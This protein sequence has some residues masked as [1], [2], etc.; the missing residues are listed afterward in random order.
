M[1]KALKIL[2]I[3]L[4]VILFA[5]IVAIVVCYC[6]IPEQ[7]KGVM[8]KIIEYLNT[9]IGITGVSIASIGYIFYKIISMTSI[10]KV[11]LRT[12]KNDFCNTV[13]KVDD[14]LAKLEEKEKELAKKEED[15]KVF[16]EGY[17]NKVNELS[18]SLIKVCET[19]PNAKIKALGEQFKGNVSILNNEINE[20][21]E[22]GKNEFANVKEKVSLIDIQ[23]KYDEL[24]NEL[25]ALK[26]K[27][28]YGEREETT[29]D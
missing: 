12:L 10:G 18:D 20:K 19:I 23:G 6:V 22:Q 29:N 4:Y 15:L 28:E 3:S 13:Q 21:L 1:N 5:C 17:S 2:K 14:G 25:K 9:P 26:E 7:A 16:V 11:G 27:V 24:L 8:D